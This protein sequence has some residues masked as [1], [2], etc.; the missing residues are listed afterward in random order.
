M[1]KNLCLKVLAFSHRNLLEVKLA[2]LT[3]RSSL[4]KIEPSLYHCQR[5]KQ[6]SMNRSSDD[7]L[8]LPMLVGHPIY[9][10]ESARATFVRSKKHPPPAEI[11]IVKKKRLFSFGPKKQERATTEKFTSAACSCCPNGITGSSGRSVASSITFTERDADEEDLDELMAAISLSK[12]SDAGNNHLDSRPFIPTRQDSVPSL[13]SDTTIDSLCRGSTQ[14]SDNPPTKPRRSLSFNSTTQDELAAF[15]SR[16]ADLFANKSEE[17]RTEWSTS[18][19]QDRKLPTA[20]HL[21]RS[22]ETEAVDIELLSRYAAVFYAVV[23][24]R[25]RKH[26][27]LTFKNCFVGTEAVNS[28]LQAGL[29]KTREEGVEIGRQLMSKF[30]LFKHVTCTHTFKD[31]NLLY[32]F[33]FDKPS[34][35]VHSSWFSFSRTRTRTQTQTIDEIK[36]LQT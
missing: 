19:D 35:K 6:T 9:R 29:A 5:G 22:K 21:A 23:E 12:E 32:R 36:P 8:S 34:E 16:K 30:S 31:K 18:I 17:L 28:I 4:F 27:I 1:I 33:C 7:S 26:G 11:A 25:D 10:G 2:T 24:V 13:S 20:L 3:H 14:V 15:S